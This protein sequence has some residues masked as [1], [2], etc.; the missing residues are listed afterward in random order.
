MRELWGGESD[1]EQVCRGCVGR[2]TL[3]V[4]CLVCDGCDIGHLKIITA[5]VRRYGRLVYV[6]VFYLECLVCVMNVFMSQS[7]QVIAE[8]SPAPGKKES[9]PERENAVPAYP[10]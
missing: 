3:W 2:K 5:A 9:L 1:E 6:S 4:A 7:S 10:L 8:L